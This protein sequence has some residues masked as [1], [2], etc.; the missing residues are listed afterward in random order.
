[1]KD[2]NYLNLIEGP[3]QIQDYSYF[4]QQKITFFALALVYPFA[5]HEYN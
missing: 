5:G 2:N 1:M 3:P 4:W